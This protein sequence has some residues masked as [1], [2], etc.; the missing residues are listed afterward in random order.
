[1][2]AVDAHAD[3]SEVW[4]TDGTLPYSRGEGVD[5]GL[6]KTAIVA[7]DVV[8]IIAQLQ[9]S[10]RV[11]GERTVQMTRMILLRAEADEDVRE[12]RDILTEDGGAAEAV[13]FSNAST[14]HRR[15]L[16]NIDINSLCT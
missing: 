12:L 14:M 6:P 16:A 7:G 11:H 5:V 9:E 3:E 13:A 2:F 1:M 10:V 4:I 15:V 8:C